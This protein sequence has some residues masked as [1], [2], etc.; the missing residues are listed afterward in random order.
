MNEFRTGF[1]PEGQLDVRAVTGAGARL[2]VLEAYGLDALENDPELTAIARFAARLCG[3]WA[4]IVNLVEAERQR[5]LG[6]EGLT[7]LEAEAGP[8]SCCVHTMHGGAP[9]EVPDA[10]LDARFADNPFVT[11]E[12]YL[13]FYAGFPLVSPEGVPLGALCVIDP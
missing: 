1:L 4:A 6:R 5:F 8:A 11:G 12:P 10:S 7:I 3:T 13:R 9:L 2:G